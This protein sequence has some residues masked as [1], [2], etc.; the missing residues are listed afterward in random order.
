MGSSD[1]RLEGT[2]SAVS[3]SPLWRVGSW[4]L[5][6]S[7]D[8]SADMRGYSTD[9][10]GTSDSITIALLLSELEFL[11][12]RLS[13][14]RVHA[15]IGLGFGA[16]IGLSLLADRPS[17]SSTFV[18]IGFAIPDSRI[19]PRQTAVDDWA[20]R[21]SLARRVGM[22]NTADKACA[23][24]FTVDARGSPEWVRVRQMIATG[25]IEGME[26]LSNAVLECVGDNTNRRGQKM[27]ESLEIPTLFLCG[28]S[29]AAFP[30]EMERYPAMMK[31]EKGAFMLIPRASRLACCENP[32]GFA[33]ILK[34]WL[35]GFS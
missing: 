7:A 26:K 30:E 13:L 29:D 32:S 5:R 1:C 31:K 25:S 22:G 17:I 9:S 28:S 16:N 6:I 2:L 11:L 10:L 8:P 27:L 3:F 33:N 15:L 20:L 35:D 18:G 14:P 21:S 24:W 12:E 23:R 34:S 4:I 19:I